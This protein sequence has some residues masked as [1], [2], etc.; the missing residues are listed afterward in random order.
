MATQLQLRKGTKIQNDTFTGAQGELTMCTD[1]NGLRVHDGHTTGGFEVPVLVAVQRPTAENNYT[2]CRK[3]SDGWVEQGGQRVASSST[4]TITL[5]VTMADDK[6]TVTTAIIYGGTSTGTIGAQVSKTTTTI[7]IGARWNGAFND[8]LA[9]D[10]QVSG[11][12]A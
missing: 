6:Y 2:W 8:G 3:W 11:M 9:V 4:T 5:P 7:T 10:W 1:T 12:A